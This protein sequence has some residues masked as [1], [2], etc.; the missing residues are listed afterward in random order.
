M[1]GVGSIPEVYIPNSRFEPQMT[2]YPSQSISRLRDRL[3]D[4]DAI[5]DADAE[6]LRAFSDELRILGA[7]QYSDY[8]HEKYLMRLVAIA[9]G[10]GGLAA[11]L[12]DEDAA[13]RIVAWINAEKNDSPETNKDYRVSLR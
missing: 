10:V 13:R 8:A 6:T 4:S 9:E 2:D 5:S 1:P 11:A 3:E 12:D 7:S